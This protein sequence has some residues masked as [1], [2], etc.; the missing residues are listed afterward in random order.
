MTELIAGS[1]F[2]LILTV[3]L[4]GGAI[5]ALLVIVLVKAVSKDDKPKTFTP[6]AAVTLSTQSKRHSSAVLG[7][8]LVGAG[9]LTGLL[10]SESEAGA[11]QAPAAAFLLVW[12]GLGIGLNGR[13]LLRWSGGFLLA[14]AV[15]AF[16]LGMNR[17]FFPGTTQP[18]AGDGSNT[19]LP[20]PAY[21]VLDRYDLLTGGHC[22][23]GEKSA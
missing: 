18:V 21:T 20:L 14:I 9:F 10:S 7:W 19:E 2:G 23:V 4:I 5:I 11:S 16:S 17:A 3:M 12:I 8:F 1:L 6:T 13:P 22:Q 15:T